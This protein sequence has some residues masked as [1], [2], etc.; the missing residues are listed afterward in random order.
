MS[1]FTRSAMAVM[2]LLVLAMVVRDPAEAHRPPALREAP[3]AA[4]TESNEV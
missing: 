2:T 3:G 1:G 4:R